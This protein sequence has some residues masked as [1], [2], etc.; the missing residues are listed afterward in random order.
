MSSGFNAAVISALVLH[1]RPFLPLFSVQLIF[2]LLK[3]LPGAL[4]FLDLA[5]VRLG[6][7]YL[8]NRPGCLNIAIIGSERMLYES[9]NDK[10]K[11]NISY[12]QAL[13]QTFLIAAYLAIF[14]WISL[15]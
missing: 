6:F 11:A 1:R 13:L 2:I 14:M 8:L 10:E 4:L 12:G 15:S 3:D 5:R 7:R 9:S